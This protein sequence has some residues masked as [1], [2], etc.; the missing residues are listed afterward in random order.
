MKCVLFSMIFSKLSKR[1][2]L[3]IPKLIREMTN[4]KPGDIIKFTIKDNQIIL[5]KIG[6]IGEESIVEF[7]K[8]GKPFEK[9]LI[10]NLR[11]E[12]E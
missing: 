12:W 3:V 10:Q 2:Q 6:P 5:E 1:G 4:I 9:D 11:D 8:K 7:L